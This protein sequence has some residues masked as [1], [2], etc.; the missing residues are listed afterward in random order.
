[1][2]S[3]LNEFCFADDVVVVAAT[4]K[5]LVEAAIES[6]RV[7]QTCGLT[8]SVPKTKFLV[9]GNDV[10]QSYLEAYPCW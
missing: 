3:W 9:A 5:N 4:K 8:I 1:M 10:T 2:S 7:V 6:D